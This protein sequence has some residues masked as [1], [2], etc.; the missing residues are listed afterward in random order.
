MKYLL[1][2][3]IWQLLVL[4]FVCH[5][6][7]EKVLMIRLPFVDNYLDD[8]LCMPI[9]LGGLLAEQM[10]LFKRQRLTWVEGLICFVLISCLFELI[11]PGFYVGYTADVWDLC[12]YA[13]GGLFFFLFLN[14]KSDVVYH[15]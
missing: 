7:L 11:L 10:D 1:K 5:Q 8:L 2:N 14:P 3:R 9:L 4:L 15:F 6:V 13:C 12:C